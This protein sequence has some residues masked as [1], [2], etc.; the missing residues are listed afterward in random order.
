MIDFNQIKINYP[1]AVIKRNSKAIIVE[2]LQY[3]LMDA[4]FK[5]AGSENLSFIGGTAIRLVYG[6]KRFSEDLD[7][8]NYGLTYAD[9][10]KLLEA[11]V[12]AMKAKGFMVDF[13]FVKKGAYHCYIKFPDLLFANNL[14]AHEDEKI[15]I[16]VDAVKKKK[17][18]E[19]HSF[20][21]N[22]FNVYRK[23][24]VNQ[25]D[26]I[27]SQ[28]ILA[29]LERK[30]AKGRDFFDVSY[31]LSFNRPNYNVLE[32]LASIKEKNLKEK[33]LEKVDSLNMK[34]LADDVRPLL[35]D[36]NDAERVLSFRQYIEQEL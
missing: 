29:I 16:R 28:K 10:E 21:L 4:L 5:E 33:L 32:K 13:R 14:T 36:S 26:V 7:F 23:I 9:F 20:M 19:P 11:V 1:E 30:R 6:S 25:A 35:F 2:Y 22:G 15:L 34:E 12:G 17:I 27:L 24:L 18:I 31:L 3:Q 8:Y